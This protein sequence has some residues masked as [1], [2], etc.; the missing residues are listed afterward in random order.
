M[1]R[2]KVFFLIIIFYCRYE[3]GQRQL[4]V[5]GR[6]RKKNMADRL[7][8]ARAVCK[9]GENNRRQRIEKRW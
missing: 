5:H 1:A 7:G 9:T 8:V 4:R 6:G 2:G 3:N